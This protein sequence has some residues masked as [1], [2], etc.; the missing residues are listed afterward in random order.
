MNST[1][2]SNKMIQNKDPNI[3]KQANISHHNAYKNSYQNS[4][5]KLLNVKPINTFERFL[6]NLS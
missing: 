2:S 3:Q 6:K 1:Q 5:D 4:N